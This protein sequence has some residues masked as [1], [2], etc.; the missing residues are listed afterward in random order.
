M[1]ENGGGQE[2][3][4]LLITVDSEIGNLRGINSAINALERLQGLTGNAKGAIKQLGDLGVA[5][6][7]FDGIG[8]K[9]DGIDNV[10]S[11]VHRMITALQRLTQ[12]TGSANKA[13][14]QLG[15]LGNTLNTSFSGIGQNLAGIEN[16]SRGI[17][18]LV[19]AIE[20]LSQVTGNANSSSRQLGELG[21][22]LKSFENVNMKNIADNIAQPLER[23]MKAIGNL[24]NNNQISIRVDQNG[25]ANVNRI[26]QN[27]RRTMTTFRE[28]YDTLEHDRGNV[29]SLFGDMFDITQPTEDLQRNLSRAQRMLGTFENSARTNAERVRSAMSSVDTRSLM[30]NQS[31]RNAFRASRMNESMADYVRTQIADMRSD[32]ENRGQQ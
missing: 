31:F 7:N 8:H 16:V 21:R 3:D 30:N 2:L 4:T 6:K 28:F 20:R 24:G 15:T 9:L 5:L 1:A 29:A 13:I 11:G 14:K 22:Q 25:V 17:L 19:T 10:T 32:I 18:D 27:L 12:V 26:N 23:I